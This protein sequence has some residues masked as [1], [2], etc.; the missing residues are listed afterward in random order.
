[1]VGNR[2]IRSHFGFIVPCICLEG[3][4]DCYLVEVPVG[5]PAVEIAGVGGYLAVKIGNILGVPEGWSH[6]PVPIL[7]TKNASPVVA[8]VIGHANKE[9]GGEVLGMGSQ[10]VCIVADIYFI[11]PIKI[12]RTQTI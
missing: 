9:K 8:A 7:G 3:I 4:A 6:V 12:D 10:A 2:F 11:V 5:V 1:M